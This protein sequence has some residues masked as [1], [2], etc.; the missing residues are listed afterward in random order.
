MRNLTTFFSVYFSICSIGAHQLYCSF[1]FSDRGI[2]IIKTSKLREEGVREEENQRETNWTLGRIR[3]ELQKDKNFDK[4]LINNILKWW[5]D[6]FSWFF[7]RRFAKVCSPQ[8][9][10]LFSRALNC[11]KLH[12][13]RQTWIHFAE[14]SCYLSE[15]THQIN[16]EIV[17]LRDVDMYS[18]YVSVKEFG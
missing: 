11:L 13:G 16:I 1:L 2:C 12:W 8:K 10:A 14:T 6:K 17:F 3:R 5:L 9:W 18:F 7:G 4:F 15:S